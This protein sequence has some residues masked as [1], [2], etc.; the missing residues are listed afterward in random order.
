MKYA[1][2]STEKPGFSLISPWDGRSGDETQ[3]IEV[4]VPLRPKL[5]I[6]ESTMCKSLE[7]I[8]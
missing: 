2:L 5:C 3:A 8:H 4:R 6:I 1:T 7:K